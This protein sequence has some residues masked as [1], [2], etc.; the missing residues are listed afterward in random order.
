MGIFRVPL[1]VGNPDNGSAE[2]VE[3]L[4]DTGATFSM[5][6]AS[7]L[8]RLGI[9]AVRPVNFRIANGGT[10]E[11]PTGMASFAAEGCHGAARVVFGPEDHYL[12]GATTLEDLLL[13]VDPVGQRL[14]PVEGSLM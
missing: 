7:L 2:T 13:T 10:V 6:P 3:A 12:M 5:M 9:E 14:V 8:E 4:V 11:Y 1:Q